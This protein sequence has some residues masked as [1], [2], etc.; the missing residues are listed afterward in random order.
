M[1]DLTVDP[2]APLSVKLIRGG[3]IYPS[4]RSKDLPK[5]LM[6]GVSNSAG[7]PDKGIDDDRRHGSELYVHPQPK[8]Y[9]TPTRRWITTAV[10]GGVIYNHF[11]HFLLESLSRAWA[12]KLY[13]RAKLVWSGNNSGGKG[14]D[15][16]RWQKDIL[17]ILGIENE[18]EIV[19]EPT[20]FRRLYLPDPGYRYANWFSAQHAKF[21]GQYE[22]FEQVSGKK[23]WLSRRGLKGLHVVNSEIWERRLKLDG[24]DVIQPEKLS[25]PEQLAYLA[26]AEI[27]A[28]EEGSAFHTVMLLKDLTRKKLKIFRRHGPEHMSF[29]TIGKQRNIDQEFFSNKNEVVLNAKGREVKRLAASASEALN[30]LQVPILEGVKKESK[31]FDTSRRILQAKEITGAKSYL[32]IGVFNGK[33]F[34]NVTFDR[35]VAVDPAFQ[36]DPRSIKD[37]TA[38][39]FEVTSDQYFLNFCK[40]EKF[41]IFFIDGLHTYE[42][43]LRDFINTLNHANDRSI[44]LIDDIYP[45]DIFSAFP[46][47]SRAVAMRAE[48]GSKRK[49]WHG[50]VYKLAYAIHDFFPLFSY[51]TIKTGGNPQLL[52]WKKPRTDFTPIFNDTEA[53]ARLDY[54]KFRELQEPL[55]LASEEDAFASLAEHF[56]KKG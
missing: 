40:S 21:L 52:L 30:H 46:D 26:K 24:W 10:Y 41:D 18:I 17:K 14:R 28:G 33:T 45:L 2:N 8:R 5:K 51:R 25:V 43:T 13:P 37:P 29:H 42:Q 20:R 32:E 54:F 11:G 22:A 16:T 55:N 27:V 36:F 3:V 38:E 56:A 34:N 49:A 15:L 4:L 9:K 44:W 39:F 12:A 7:V 35:K 23:L 53:I 50:D 6:V 47:Q 31:M 19:V 48:T 1:Q